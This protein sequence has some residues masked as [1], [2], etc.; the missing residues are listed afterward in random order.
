M[1]QAAM[2]AAAARDLPPFPVV[3]QQVM[4]LVRSPHSSA[5]DLERVISRDSALAARVLKISNS[6]LYGV[7]GTITT[8]SRAAVIL[9]MKTL[10]SL[11]IAASAEALYRTRS[12][13]DKL[14]WDHSLAVALVSRWLARKKGYRGTEEA[15]VAGLLHDIGKAVL[16]LNLPDHY[17]E[18]VQLVYNEGATFLQAENRLLGFDHAEVGT[19]VVRKWNLA[20]ALQEAVRL[21]HDPEL[22]R[23]DPTLCALVCLANAICVRLGVGPERFPE[24]D[25]SSL[26]CRQMLQ[27]QNSELPA[28]LEEIQEKLAAEEDL[29]GKRI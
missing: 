12:F 14:L 23:L 26:P 24:L 11:V 13:K 17:Q 15:F 20:P 18:V 4:Q 21:H 25:L 7:R 10:Q 27:F 28:M 3:A 5:S 6:A 9:G 29:F 1:N 8:L 2:V 19:I 22:A 16:D